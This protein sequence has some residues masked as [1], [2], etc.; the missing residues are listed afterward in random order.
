MIEQKFLPTVRLVGSG[1]L[2]ITELVLKG[3]RLSNMIQQTTS[4]NN[5]NGAYI[6]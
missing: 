6:I 2:I 3:Q 1:H 4:K 5:K